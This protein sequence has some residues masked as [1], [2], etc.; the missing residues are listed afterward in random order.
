MDTATTP[1]GAMG[2]TAEAQTAYAEIRKSLRD[3]S[4]LSTVGTLLS[5]DQEVL[6]PA[7]AGAFRA[8]QLAAMSK[9]SHQ[10]RTDPRLGERIALCETDSALTSDAQEG[11]NLRE[12]RREFDRA[13]K[14]PSDLVVA[15]AQTS[16]LAMEAWKEARARS[17]FALF[18]PHLTRIIE[19]SKEQAHCWGAPEDGELYDALLDEYE[20]GARC[21]DVERMFTP[22]RERL[23]PFIS[24]VASAPRSPSEAI[25]K[26][27]APIDAQKAFCHFIS[28]AVGYDFSAGRLDVSTH[29]FTESMGPRDVRITTRY[30]E[31]HFA[32]ASL[33]TLHEVGHAMYEQGLPTQDRFG[34]P[35]GTY[36]SLGAHESQSRLWENQIGRSLAFW[37]WALPASRK[38]FGGAL[39]G[40]SPQ[41]AF[42][43]VNRVRPHFIR[44]ESDEATYH[45]HIMLRFDLERALIRGELN[46]ADIPGAWN[47]RMKR[48]LGLVVPDDR[49]GCLQDIHW[50]M[51]AV[52]YFPTYTIGSLLACQLWEAL[53]RDIPDARTL[54]EKGEFAPLL[55]W[56][57]TNVHTHGRRYR[58]DE[59][60]ERAT[61][62]PLS[63]EPLMRHLR[64]KLGPIYGLS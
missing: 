2:A 31:A 45:L 43:G 28:E 25:D 18:E 53:V 8:E 27:R 1:Q 44:V 54:V 14:L 38:F 48:D 13:T 41:Q 7:D 26:I 6:M 9:L 19:L 40:L 16:S 64:S 21:A 20:P 57:R 58:T 37:T 46:V 36:A 60:C 55:A 23:A 11:A 42:E 50:S 56:T 12:I 52:G 30:S 34:E 10:R 15:L 61:G 35:I 3:A 63:H 17:D 33:T 59:L 32:D 29:P 62:A 4:I 5:W 24:E 22:L 49:L 47:E 51:G 39:A